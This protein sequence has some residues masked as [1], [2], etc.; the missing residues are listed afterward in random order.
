MK[1]EHLTYTDTEQEMDS[2]GYQEWSTLRKTRIFIAYGVIF[3]VILPVLLFFAG[4][5]ADSVLSNLIY[6]PETITLYGLVIFALG[7]ILTA[8]SM[9]QLTVQGEGFPISHLPPQK[10]VTNGFYRMVRHPIYTGF[11]LLMIGCSLL[12]RSP[13]MILISMPILIA[14][15]LCYI[16]FFEEPRLEQRYGDSYRTYKE[17]VP[18]LLPALMPKS[19]RTTMEPLKEKTVHLINT[20]ANKTVLFRYGDAIFVT[21]GLLTAAGIT[22]FM[23]HCAVTLIAQGM[24]G[25]S[26][27]WF[28]AGAA[29]AGVAGARIYWWI[30]HIGTLIREPWFGLRKVGF[31]SWGVVAGLVMFVLPYSYLTGY[32]ILL[33]SDAVFSGMFIGY[34]IGRIGCLTYGCCCG[35]VIDS[36]GIV[37]R[38]PES[39]V[40][41]LKKNPGMPRYP[42][43]IYSAAHGLL[44]VLILNGILYLEWPAGMLTAFA[45]IYYGI[46]R[47]YEEFYRDRA[48]IG[49]TFLTEGHV[50][51]VLFVIG[52][53][54]LVSLI[55]AGSDTVL[56]AW[57]ADAVRESLSVAPVVLLLGVMQ[58]LI[59]GYHYKE[60]GKW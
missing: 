9:G 43:Q 53:L 32:S 22:L 47:F 16:R 54:L 44:L 17:K 39:K 50:G 14:G 35:K 60:I 57:T 25:A 33:L 12:L 27:A 3:L 49:D 24:S 41:R 40:N 55:D 51:S 48:R 45:L 31:V 2:S 59:M 46:G 10:M 19:L 21:Y 15:T 7:G 23:Q 38:N 20:I 56:R 11:L 13:G 37:Y 30:E 1:T 42:T 8:G 26:A 34:A 5:L 18:A 6:L 28:I 36:P 58:F 52:G 4:K 29:I